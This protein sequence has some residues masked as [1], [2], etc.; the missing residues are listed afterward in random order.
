MAARL[1]HNQKADGSSPS[2]ATNYKDIEI[3]LQF[4]HISRSAWSGFCLAKEVFI[5]MLLKKC[6]KCGRFYQLNGKSCCNEC[7]AAGGQDRKENDRIYNQ[8]YRNKQSDR[9][10]HSSAWKKLSKLVL[11]KAHYR[12]A[13]CGGIATEV[14]HIVEISKD[15]SKRLDISN[16]MPLC[17]S[18]H[19][20]KR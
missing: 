17:T 1:A 6:P 14:H 11:M 19:N 4:L 5:S 8:R 10:Y 13:E 16:L 15:W 7:D 9:F 3:I 18:C 2:S 12:C 20:K